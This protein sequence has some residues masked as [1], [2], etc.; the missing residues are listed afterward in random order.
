VYWQIEEALGLLGMRGHRVPSGRTVARSDGVLEGDDE[1]GPGLA[2]LLDGVI[3]P[4]GS[5]P[6]TH[7][8]MHLRNHRTI[9]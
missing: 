4:R 5:D 6:T 1:L 7:T 3:V 8:V 9:T 2:V